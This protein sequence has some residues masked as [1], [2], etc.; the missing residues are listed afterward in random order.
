MKSVKSVILHSNPF[1]H[2]T[3]PNFNIP[4]PLQSTYARSKNLRSGKPLTSLTSLIRPPY[5]TYAAAEGGL[6]K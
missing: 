2:S 5:R 4:Q 6:Q 1:R 3:F